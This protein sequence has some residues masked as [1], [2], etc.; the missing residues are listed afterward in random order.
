MKSKVRNST[1]CPR[2]EKSQE[3]PYPNRKGPYAGPG[4]GGFLCASYPCTAQILARSD[5]FMYSGTSLLNRGTSLLNNAS[6]PTW[7]N[8]GALGIGLL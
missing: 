8:R 6:P 1:N 7:E 3:M 4:G 2:N 5:V